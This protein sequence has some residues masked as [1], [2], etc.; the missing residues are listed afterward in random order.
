MCT[1]SRCGRF[2]NFKL[3]SSFQFS[4]MFHISSFIPF[5]F[6]F[7]FVFSV[8]CFC[9]SFDLILFHIV[10]LLFVFYV[11]WFFCCCCLKMV[12]F[13]ITLT[14]CMCATINGRHSLLDHI[15]NEKK[16]EYEMIKHIWYCSKLAFIFYELILHF[17]SN[18]SFLVCLTPILF[19]FF[20]PL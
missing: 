11:D 16:S 14:S 1:Q 4:L 2:S 5:Q 3:S 7:N 20:L 18:E 15:R 9:F 17:L 13:W 19:F 10:Y 8:F 12:R 6:A